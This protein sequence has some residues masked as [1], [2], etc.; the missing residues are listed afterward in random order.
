MSEVA[1]GCFCPPPTLRERLSSSL[2]EGGG[3]GRERTSASRRG[4]M[5]RPKPAFRQILEAQNLINIKGDPKL[6]KLEIYPLQNLPVTTPASNSYVQRQLVRGPTLRCPAPCSRPRPIPSIESLCTCSQCAGT[7]AGE[8]C[9]TSVSG[10]FTGFAAAALRSCPGRNWPRGLSHELGSRST[11]PAAP[12]YWLSGQPVAVPLASH[13]MLPPNLA[14]LRRT[15]CRPAS[16]ARAPRGVHRTKHT[17]RAPRCPAWGGW[18]AHEVAR[19]GV[20]GHGR[21]GTH[22]TMAPH[23][24]GL[25]FS[26]QPLAYGTPSIAAEVE[27]RC[28]SHVLEQ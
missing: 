12:S 6:Q 4:T 10:P 3:A 27:P 7:P 8:W 11:G 9:C 26:M 23:F 20:G 17:I 1:C 21:N 22:A 28:V 14:F 13:T 2:S 18:H 15:I 19:K 24:P 5:L 16:P 25:H